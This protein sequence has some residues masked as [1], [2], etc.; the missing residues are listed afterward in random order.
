MP[1]MEIDLGRDVQSDI[2]HIDLHGRLARLDGGDGGHCAG[3]GR[4]RDESK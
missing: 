3:D 2:A 1:N 4:H